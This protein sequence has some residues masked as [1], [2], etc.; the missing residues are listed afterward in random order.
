MIFF[1][2]VPIG[3]IAAVLSAIFLRSPIP[4]VRGAP[5]LDKLGSFILMLLIA[6]LILALT[7]GFGGSY[8]FYIPFVLLIPIFILIERR[9]REPLIEFTL[10][11][12]KRFTVGNIV[13]FFS[14]MGNMLFLFQL[15][16]FL[17][18]LWGLPVGQAGFMIIASSLALAC[19]GPLAGT[20]ADRIGALRLM[21]IAL[22]VIM[23]GLISAF[24]L[25]KT[26]S[27]LHF[28]LT[29][30][31][32]GLGTGFINTPNNSEIMNS[33]GR[34]FANYAGGFVATNRNLA[35][36]IGTGASAGLFV[37]LQ[38]RFEVGFSFSD[39]Y[40]MAFHG[41]VIVSFVL[42]AISFILC[43]FLIRLEKNHGLDADGPIEKP[44]D[45]TE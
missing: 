34:R 24:L 9:Q 17:Q 33:A 18:I 15:P 32:I 29:L 31:C 10:L 25:P 4:P 36:C 5:P 23:L 43:L 35:F 20:I 38:R 1:L 41:I 22:C 27:V 30:I 40:A 16:F 6:C 13:G 21:P 8:F 19:A 42:M 14:Y 12:N 7:G 44:K 39:A 37:F 3:A 26:P 2:N 11:R 28:I 45:I